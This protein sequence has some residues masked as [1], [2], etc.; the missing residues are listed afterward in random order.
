VWLTTGFPVAER[1]SVFVKPM[2]S[3]SDTYSRMALRSRMQPVARFARLTLAYNVV[4]IIC[5]AYVR[6][7]GSGAD[8]GNHWP[9][10]DGNILPRAPQLQTVIE[11]M[12]RVTN[13]LALIMAASLLVWYWRKTSKGD[14]PRYSAVLAIILLGNEALLRAL[15]VVR[16]HVAQDQ[17]AAHALLFML[18]LCQYT[19]GACFPLID[20]SMAFK[21]RSPFCCYC[22]SA[23]VANDWNWV[24]RGDERWNHWLPRC[25]R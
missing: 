22:K 17:S 9:L 5:G 11:F 12:H 2:I 16:K 25:S 24:G 19:L 8:C 1:C 21:Q 10:C 14:W 4:V 20:R 7:T 18:T 15:L 6:A 13:V 3:R 23:R